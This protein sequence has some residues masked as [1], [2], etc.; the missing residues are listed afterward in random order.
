M[1]IKKISVD[2]FKNL[3]EVDISPEE[4]VNII[5]GEN[6]QGKTNLI[7]AIWLMSGAKSFRTTRQTDLIGF[8]RDIAKID[9][10]FNDSV[11]EQNI[12]V[13]LQKSTKEKKIL[14]RLFPFPSRYAC[15]RRAQRL[16]NLIFPN[17][18]PLK[19]PATSDGGGD[20]IKGGFV[21]PLFML[22]K[23]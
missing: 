10:V 7:E 16:I 2:G 8:E 6:A 20:F 23:V 12:S 14:L 5:C 19:I 18:N 1:I 13:T 17:G 9:L 4:K 21:S 11:R 22:R 3:C 15:A